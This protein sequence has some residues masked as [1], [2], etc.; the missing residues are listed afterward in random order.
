MLHVLSN[1]KQQLLPP[2]ETSADSCPPRSHDP[3]DRSP[4]LDIGNK[5]N[6]S[7][8]LVGKVAGAGSRSDGDPMMA[9]LLGTTSADVGAER[10]ILEWVLD[11]PFPFA[12]INRAQPSPTAQPRRGVAQALCA[13]PTSIVDS[14]QVKDRGIVFG[15]FQ[16]RFLTILDW[17]RLFSDL[18][19]RDGGDSGDEGG[20][21]SGDRD[22]RWKRLMFAVYE[23]IHCGFVQILGRR[24]EDSFEKVAILWGSGR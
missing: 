14:D 22:G 24:K 19:V 11:R 5:L 23:L 4:H 17:F 16:S 6:K 15:V 13:Y 2:R 8:V 1:W 12:S 18:V 21:I 9:A 3:A 10:E 20:R 7:I